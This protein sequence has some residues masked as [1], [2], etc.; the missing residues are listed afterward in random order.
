MLMTVAVTDA[1]ISFYARCEKLWQESNYQP[2]QAFDPDWDSPCFVVDEESVEA[3]Y[4]SWHPVKRAEK[5]SFS[6]IETA[7]NIELDPQI[8]AF[9]GAYFS[10][11][12][13]ARYQDEVI[14]LVQVWSEDD[15]ER[16]QENMIAHL[17]MKKTLKQSPTLFIASCEDDMEIIALD[18]VTGEVVRELLGKDKSEVLT[19]DLA[20]FLNAL[21]PIIVAQ[22]D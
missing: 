3:G 6:N 17:M 7:L 19:P 12:M 13:A 15:F 11:H 10:D 9:F 16:L 20:S 2:Q 21:N 8:E 4:R 18:N 1:L 22:A 5:I 14:E